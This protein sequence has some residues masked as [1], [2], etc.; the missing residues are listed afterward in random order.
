MSYFKEFFD[1]LI[2]KGVPKYTIRLDL[3]SDLVGV[4]FPTWDE[5]KILFYGDEYETE[6]EFQDCYEMHRADWLLK[7]ERNQKEL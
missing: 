1:W 4:G 7:V 2:A 6:S 3:L 5:Y